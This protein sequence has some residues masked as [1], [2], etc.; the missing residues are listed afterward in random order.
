MNLLF[1]GG[2]HPPGYKDLSSPAE[3]ARQ[4]HP[5]RVTIPLLQHVGQPCQAL[6]K[7]GDRV[8]RGQKI[9]DGTGLC[10]PVHASVS[11]VVESVEPCP[12]PVLAQAEAIVIRSD[13]PAPASTV[14]PQA[15]GK[16]QT[17]EQ[18][19]ELIREAG[20]VGQG[21]AAFPTAVKLRSA[22]DK[23]DILIANGC[24]CEPYI[25]ADCHLLTTQPRRVLQGLTIAGRILQP[26]RIFLAVERGGVPETLRSCLPEFPDVHLAVLPRRYPQGSEKQLIQALTGRQ[27]PP[28]AL[29]ADV[30]C[31]VLNVS[32][33][34]AVAQAVTT[35]APL[36]ERIVTVSGQAVAQPGSFLVPLGTPILDVIQAAGGLTDAGARIIS[37]GPMTGTAVSPQ[38]PVIKGTNGITCLPP[39]PE[40]PGTACISCGKCVEV[41]PMHL[42]PLYLYLCRNE[43]RAAE[44]LRLDDCI[45]CGCCSYICPAGLPLVQQFRHMKQLRKERGR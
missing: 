13:P 17:A 27:V 40:L 30:G 9:G 10:V 25:T 20:I 29:P 2:I 28:G 35:G 5:Q 45:G 43:H 4:I 15:A 18:L 42:L 8:R 37:G 3:S 41:C 39:Q 14:R 44:E 24:E 22:M 7:P 38:T 26:R 19:L 6:V 12:H 31:A 21:G 1:F 11:G 32:T 16:S 33:C 36:T 23:A 34:A